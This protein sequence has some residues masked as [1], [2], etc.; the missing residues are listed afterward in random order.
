MQKLCAVILQS[1]SSLTATLRTGESLGA[2]GSVRTRTVT[3]HL[4]RKIVRG[5]HHTRCGDANAWWDTF[6]AT[7]CL[8]CSL[9]L[10]RCRMR[11]LMVSS[12]LVPLL[13][14]KEGKHSKVTDDCS[15]DKDHRHEVVDEGAEFVGWCCLSSLLLAVSSL[16]P[17]MRESERK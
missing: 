17:K 10:Y 3:F 2:G 6:L 12:S 5:I 16:V 7:L 11:T 13:G 1:Q 9:P 15:I 4:W 14:R 8:G